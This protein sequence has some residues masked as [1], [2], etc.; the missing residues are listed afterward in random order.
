MIEI[1][2]IKSPLNK[3]G[4]QLYRCGFGDSPELHT[5][6]R[7]V[8]DLYLLK[9]GKQGERVEI[10]SKMETSNEVFWSPVMF[11]TCMTKHMLNVIKHTKNIC[12]TKNIQVRFCSI[13]IFSSIIIGCDIIFILSSINRVVGQRIDYLDLQNKKWS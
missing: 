1:Y 13:H 12:M 2:I 7:I 4:P 6:N 11:K 8:A 5:W 3:F 9:S 10:K